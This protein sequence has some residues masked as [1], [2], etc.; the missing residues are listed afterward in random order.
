MLE[1]S[2][3]TDITQLLDIFPT[4]YISG[5]R[6]AGK[7]T[8][9]RHLLAPNINNVSFDDIVEKSAVVQNPSSYLQ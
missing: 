8:L 7:T 4:V 2:L 3:K 9:A 5:P 6:Q 1:R